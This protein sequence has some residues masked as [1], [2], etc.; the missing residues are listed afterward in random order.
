MSFHGFGAVLGIGIGAT[1]FAGCTTDLIMSSRYSGIFDR[2]CSVR[3]VVEVWRL[4]LT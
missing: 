3:R 1:G 4:H 2:Q